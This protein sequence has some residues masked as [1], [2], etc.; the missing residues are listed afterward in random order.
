MS[1]SIAT[2]IDAF[3]TRITDL[4]GQIQDLMKEPSSSSKT[5]APPVGE[6]QALLTAGGEAGESA[7]GTA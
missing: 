3:S 4:E 7:A 6:E 1:D 2:K 5:A